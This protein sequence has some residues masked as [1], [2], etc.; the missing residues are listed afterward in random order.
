L[1]LTAGAPVPVSLQREV[2]ALL[3]MAQV[4]TP[5]GMT[6]ALPLTDVT[7]TTLEQ[8]DGAEAGNGVCVGEPLD[9]VAVGLAPLD[10]LG[11]AGRALTDKA[12]VTGE[13]CVAGPHVKDRYDRL[14]LTQH[15][16]AAD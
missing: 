8:L 11:V 2:A 15:D 1:V 3:P 14:W 13:I 16:A 10:E 5:Y 12:H 9:G 6:E 4:H 7:L